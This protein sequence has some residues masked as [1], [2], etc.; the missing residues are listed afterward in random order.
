VGLLY[1]RVVIIWISVRSAGYSTPPASLSVG[2][3][4]RPGV[5]GVAGHA[6]QAKPLAIT[7]ICPL[8]NCVRC[9][10]AGRWPAG[11]PGGAIGE[12]VHRY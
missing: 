1:V 9:R 2:G 5:A 7:R 12:R 10:Y 11:V 3:G 4:L 8:R 6:G